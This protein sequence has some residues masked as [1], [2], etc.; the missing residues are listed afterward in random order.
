MELQSV[1]A[2]NVRRFR[3]QREMS[4]TALAEAIDMT[5]Q[6]VFSYESGAKWPRPETMTMLAA[7]LKV[8]PWQLVADEGEGGSVPPELVEHV[9]AAAKACGLKISR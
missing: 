7:A 6:T 3:L 5:L 2:A 4:Q 9:A 8:R 1:F